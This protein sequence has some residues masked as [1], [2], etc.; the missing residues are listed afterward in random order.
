MKRLDLAPIPSTE[1]RLTKGVAL[2]GC[3]IDTAGPAKRIAF[4]S[5]RPSLY[6]L[7]GSLSI[8]IVFGSE[9]TAYKVV[10]NYRVLIHELVTIRSE[11]ACAR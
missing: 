7:P 9:Y 5:W 2:W 6:Q 11:Q 1:N 3:R 4:Y 8:G 10:V